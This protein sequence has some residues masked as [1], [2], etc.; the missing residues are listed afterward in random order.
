MVTETR[1]HNPAAAIL[2]SLSDAANLVTVLGL[3][4]G[5]VGILAVLRDEFYLGG[6]FLGL[7]LLCDMFDGNVARRF[8]NRSGDNA[9]LGVQLDSLADVVHGGVLPS[10]LMVAL[11]EHS[12]V[13]S[14]VA[15]ALCVAVVL[16][17][18]YFNVFG[19]VDDGSYRGL[20]VIFNSLVV[21]LAVGLVPAAYL[22]MV[23]LGG[24]ASLAALNVLGIPVPKLRGVGF[25][26]FISVNLIA[27]FANLAA[28][29]GL[30]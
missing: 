21:A 4:A 30:W 18:A 3:C 26:L 5:I 10:L 6:A 8:P 17:L 2:R 7:A 12:A 28:A 22:G 24:A 16:R 19:L 13:S 29:V 14:I 27:V 20:P 23:L 9:R 11:S 15:V 25:W 1:S